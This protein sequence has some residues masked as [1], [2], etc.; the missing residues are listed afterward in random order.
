MGSADFWNSQEAAQE[1]VQQVKGLKNWVEPFEALS[2][3]AVQRQ[4]VYGIVDHRLIIVGGLQGIR[5][6]QIESRPVA[7]DVERPV[8]YDR[9]HPPA[10][11]SELWIKARRPLPYLDEG[12]VH[13]LLRKV[14]ATHY[15][16]RDADQARGL[17]IVKAAQ[18]L[19]IAAATC[20]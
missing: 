5:I 12:I 3:A 8:A 4:S 7:Y 9:I 10:R 16:L 15:A 19:P 14:P 6:E 1:V 11:R 20:G 17:L 13:D 2:Q 18:R